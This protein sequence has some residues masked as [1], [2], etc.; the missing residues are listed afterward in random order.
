MS[1]VGDF[2]DSV[3]GKDR[4]LFSIPGGGRWP[5]ISKGVRIHTRESG[6]AAQV[7][8]GIEESCLSKK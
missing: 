1:S 8:K 3:V 6:Q 5:E 7:G 2:S 4:V